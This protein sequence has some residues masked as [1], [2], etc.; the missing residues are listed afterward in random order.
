VDGVGDSNDYLTSGY[1]SFPLHAFQQMTLW[2]SR[3]NSL[4]HFVIY[5]HL[6]FGKET[7]SRQPL[8]SMEL[9][10][11][12]HL[13][14][15]G[16]ISLQF[17]SGFWEHISSIKMAPIFLAYSFRAVVERLSKHFQVPTKKKFSRRNRMSVPVTKFSENK[18]VSF[19]LPKKNPVLWG[20][21]ATLAR[22][23]LYCCP[24]RF[25]FRIF[26]GYFKSFFL[27]LF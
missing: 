14:K 4:P 18:R 23:I 6:F 3:M 16:S 26:C 11:L 19:H 9:A 8:R 22:L 27:K 10:C 7:L 20:T 13:Q 2:C 24:S 17:V 1:V 21:I 5:N 12:A 25:S 15:H